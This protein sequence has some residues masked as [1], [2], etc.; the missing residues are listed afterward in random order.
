MFKSKFSVEVDFDNGNDIYIQIIHPSE[1]E[2]V[3]DNML[4]YF[5]QQL[6]HLSKWLTI[7]WSDK[8]RDGEAR[9]IIKPVRPENFGV[10]VADMQEAIE[11]RTAYWKMIDQ[12]KE[13]A[14]DAGFK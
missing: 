10:N 14:K 9:I 8:H 3:R 5:L 13:L 12:Q 2:D 6:E 1:I 11:K 7:E 4:R